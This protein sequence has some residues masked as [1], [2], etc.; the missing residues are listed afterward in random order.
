MKIKSTC[1]KIN[2]ILAYIVI[3]IVLATSAIMIMSGQI[4]QGLIF[5]A[6]GFVV[7]SLVFGVWFAIS[8]CYE[9]NVKQ[10]KLLTKLLEE[11]TKE[12]TIEIEGEKK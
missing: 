4:G 12:W 9:E 11:Q 5:G 1:L 10:T 2:D 3:G 6:V 7:C 8:G